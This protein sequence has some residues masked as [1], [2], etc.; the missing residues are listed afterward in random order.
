MWY[1]AVTHSFLVLSTLLSVIVE[2][3]MNH[4]FADEQLVYLQLLDFIFFH[5]KYCLKVFSFL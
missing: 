1:I 5:Q 4:A 3:L 2:H